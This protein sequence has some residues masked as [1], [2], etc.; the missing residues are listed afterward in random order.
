MTAL[1]EAVHQ[2]QR[3]AIAALGKRYIAGKEQ[4]INLPVLL[5]S[6]GATDDIEKDTLISCWIYLRETGSQAPEAPAQESRS[7]ENDMAT[8]KQLK[9]IERMCDERKLIS[10][11]LPL[12]KQ[13]AHEIIESIKAGT[14]NPDQWAVPF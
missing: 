14:Y 1:S 8:D 3:A 5:D 11:D 10:P 6:F 12:T 13:Q 4:D 9:A 2:A 7:A